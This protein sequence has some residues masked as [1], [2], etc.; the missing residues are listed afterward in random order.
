MGIDPN[1]PLLPN[2]ATPGSDQLLLELPQI[3][4]LIQQRNLNTP[5][6]DRIPLPSLPSEK[7]GDNLDGSYEFASSQPDRPMPAAQV[8]SAAQADPRN[9]RILSRVAGPRGNV[10]P[11]FGGSPDA[12]MDGWDY[13]APSNAR[14]GAPAFP[15]NDRFGNWSSP[16]ADDF[17]NPSS[18]L[19]RELIRRRNAA[20]PNAP[21]QSTTAFEMPGS[22][23][24]RL[25]L[26]ATH[27]AANGLPPSAEA[28]PLPLAPAGLPVEPLAPGRQ[29]SFNDRFGDWPASASP[30]PAQIDPRDVR[31]LRGRIA[32]A[33]ARSVFDTGTPAVPYVP[34]GVSIAPG[35][36]DNFDERFGN[37]SS[38]QANPAQNDPPRTRVLR[39][40]IE[41]PDGSLLPLPGSEPAPQPQAQPMT[42]Y[43]LPLPLSGPPDQ[44]GSGSDMDDWLN[45]WMPL[46]RR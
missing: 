43:G 26:E 30:Q 3:R 37:W 23:F 18:P 13:F 24:G 32:G 41:Q 20:M 17:D 44:S 38:P 2:R 34:P 29:D 28:S 1:S 9:I 33:P 36:Q 11:G 40:Y 25:L 4:D 46:F 27:R 35:Q 19:L 21:V 22:T 42:G 16:P 8:V 10:S 5:E 6:E 7:R 45:R 31:V 15:F 14:P 39:G 12:R